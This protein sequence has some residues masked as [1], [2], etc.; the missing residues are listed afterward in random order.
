MNRVPLIVIGLLAAGV[1]GC[2]PA[3]PTIATA[4]PR[5]EA[6]PWHLRDGRVWSGT[7][8]DARHALGPQAETLKPFEPQRVWLASYDEPD[9]PDQTI[10]VRAYA[11]DS[12]DAAR[13]A[14]AALRPATSDPFNAGDEA[15]WTADG[16][17]VRWGRV[18][19]DL[20]TTAG[21]GPV[22]PERVT[23][24]FSVIERR[25]TPSLASDPQ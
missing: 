11:F 13:R 2:A 6:P 18:V 17:L 25:M 20:F 12:S 1:G 22:M 7:F 23:P 5:G 10:S 4:L 19:F 16:L 24:L 9:R 8:E 15:C 21:T 14:F 3:H